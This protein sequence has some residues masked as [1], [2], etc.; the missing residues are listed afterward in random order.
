MD[1]LAEKLAQAAGVNA[2]VAK[3]IEKEADD[4]IAREEVLLERSTA[5]FDPHHAA[6][7]D[8]MKELDRFEDSLQVVEN[9]APPLKSGGGSTEH[10]LVDKLLEDA[11]TAGLGLPAPLKPG[12]TG[13]VEPGPAIG[14]DVH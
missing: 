7:N 2:R 6:L 1:R 9:A 13:A 12:S 14:A 5:A 11:V 3:A 10:K 8:R 4:L